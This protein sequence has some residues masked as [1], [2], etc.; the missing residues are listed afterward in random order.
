MNLLL[1]VTFYYVFIQLF[2]LNNSW[3]DFYRGVCWARAVSH[4][5][6]GMTLMEPN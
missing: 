4:D 5:G 6:L 1:F 2:K 3:Y